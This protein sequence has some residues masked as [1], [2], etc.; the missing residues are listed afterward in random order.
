MA[1]LVY[2]YS[3]SEGIKVLNQSA[4]R[5]GITGSF[6]PSTTFCPDIPGILKKE[7]EKPCSGLYT[8]IYGVRIGRKPVF[9]KDCFSFV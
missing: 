1:E 4:Y 8:S 9:F 3:M 2:E 6:S 7:P 5:I